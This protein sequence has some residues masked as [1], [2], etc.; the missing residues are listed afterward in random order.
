M[1]ST[2][3]TVVIAARVDSSNIAGD[4]GNAY[5][6]ISKFK[7]DTSAWDQ[8]IAEMRAGIRALKEDLANDVKAAKKLAPDDS[9]LNQLNA[10][11]AVRQKLMEVQKNQLNAVIRGRSDDYAQQKQEFAEQQ[12]RAALQQRL[13]AM[14]QQAA[15]DAERNSQ[16]LLDA[17]VQSEI[18]AE[19]EIEAIRRKGVLADQ[20]QYKQDLEA[21]NEFLEEKV[22]AEQQAAE[23]ISAIQE[24]ADRLYQQKLDRAAQSGGGSDKGGGHELGAGWIKRMAY[25]QIARDAGNLVA[26]GLGDSLAFGAYFAAT[27]PVLGAAATA[28]AVLSQS[29]AKLREDMHSLEVETRK[30]NDSVASTIRHWEEAAQADI[31]TTKLGKE[32]YSEE[33]QAI[34]KRSQL[35]EKLSQF[36][37]ESRSFQSFVG[38]RLQGGMDYVQSLFGQ[39]PEGT[40][41]D[42][43]NAQI[44]KEMSDQDKLIST[45][46]QSRQRQY[47][48]SQSREAE[49][50]GVRGGVN[51]ASVALA[52]RGVT[53]AGTPS[54]LLREQQEASL[55]FDEAEL[56][57]TSSTNEK[58]LK[59]NRDYQDGI[60]R[61]NQ[62]Y[63]ETLSAGGSDSEATQAFNIENARLA[64]QRAFDQAQIDQESQHQSQL[65]EITRKAAEERIQLEQREYD[66]RIASQL[67]HSEIGL[68]A[69]PLQ[70]RLDE[71]QQALRD[72][73]AEAGW[74]QLTEAQK[75][76][77]LRTQENINAETQKEVDYE[78]EMYEIE[79]RR[80]D[81]EIDKMNRDTQRGAYMAGVSREQ[82]RDIAAGNTRAARQA[83]IAAEGG[84]AAFADQEYQASRARANADYNALMYAKQHN[85]SPQQIAELQ[86]QLNKDNAE[87]AALLQRAEDLHQKFKEDQQ[88]EQTAHDRMVNNQLQSVKDATA[89][90]L[91]IMTPLQARLQELRRAGDE[92][93]NQEKLALVR[94]EK[95]RTNAQFQHSLLGK[96]LDVAEKRSLL[97]PLQADYMRL[98]LANPDVDDSLLRQMAMLDRVGKGEMSMKYAAGQVD[99]AGLYGSMDG[100]GGGHGSMRGRIPDLRG[101]MMDL[102]HG[103][104]DMRGR[105]SSYLQADPQHKTNL[106]LQQIL[107]MMKAQQRNGVPVKG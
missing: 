25:M 57:R 78:R 1:G 21:F 74:A 70:R 56:S 77:R 37:H 76:V 61:M 54:G 100:P 87:S 88:N 103:I 32:A 9:A 7:P 38:Y 50:F 84:E 11:I 95:E 75:E 44:R 5:Q 96:E 72:M 28:A 81:L 2:V 51:A 17:R 13:T 12:E 4:L 83:G 80:R 52:G 19:Q 107:N 10:E 23:E 105:I 34:E 104:P 69:D 42:A 30:Y 20:Q 94:A 41:Y 49:D 106:L 46:R 43:M 40:T 65:N 71:G 102:R 24:E 22:Q 29:V 90:A 82:A 101:S 92:M 39:V 62:T 47:E 14:Q 8:K 53:L 16:E 31:R 86:A 3:R 67:R 93:S 48:I 55:R 15:R 26:P 58:L 36:H 45:L 97:N 68:E 99:F 6:Q 85:A 98:K 64:N 33:N 18:N 63:R 59:M 60:S 79:Q 89:V 35:Q 66:I 27:N 73:Q 91:G